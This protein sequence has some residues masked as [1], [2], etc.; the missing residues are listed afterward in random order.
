[1]YKVLSIFTGGGGL[2]IGC[3]G[4]FHYLGKYF[5]RLN[6]KT[7]AVLDKD[8]DSCD[9]I[10][11]DTKYFEN[12]KVYH[13]DILNFDCRGIPDDH[14]DLLLGGF[15]CVTFSLVGKKAGIKDDIN[16]KLYEKYAQYV[17]HFLPKVFVAENVKGIL[18]ANKGEAIKVIRKRFEETGYNVKVF[19]V[20]FA[21]LGVPQLRQRVLFIGV[22]KNIKTEF[23]PPEFTHVGNHVSV[24]EAFE[25]I[26]TNCPNHTFIK[27]LDS[28]I[29]K[30][31]SIPEGGNYEDLPEHLAVKGLMSNIYRRLER[32]KPAYTVIASGGGG[33]WTYHYEEPRALTNRERARLQGFPDDFKFKGTNTEV[34]RQIGNAVPPVGMYPIAKRIQNVLDGV[35]PCLKE[36]KFK[37]EPEMVAGCVDIPDPEI[38]ETD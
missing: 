17:E 38:P 28:T 1:M 29:E 16:G 2:D 34:R 27:Q 13:E 20:N 30:I 24:I 15:P 4:D 33:T 23:I 8:K 21:D 31:N 26:D 25:D 5:P 37:D 14:F 6:F 32:D 22:R 36:I 11:D 35:S 7:I 9:T 18:S 19:L 3:H 10:T 12:T